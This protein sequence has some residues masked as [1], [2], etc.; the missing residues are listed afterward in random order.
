[1]SVQRYGIAP[2]KTASALAYLTILGEILVGAGLLTDRFRG[3]FLLLAGLLF[4]C[5]GLVGVAALRRP[6]GGTTECGCLGEHVRL[7][8]DRFVVGKNLLVA[9]ACFAAASATRLGISGNPQPK[10]PAGV[11]MACAVLVAGMYWLS[12]Y[13][14]AVIAVVDEALEAGE[15]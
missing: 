15:P 8:M 14:D 12:S 7:R 13:A 4:V 2:P 11:I 3:T 1:M 6:Y 9:V 10:P 5:F